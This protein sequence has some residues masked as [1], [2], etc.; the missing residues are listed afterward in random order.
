MRYKT[1]SP[2]SY[3]KSD[4]FSRSF[5]SYDVPSKITHSIIFK[6]T[7]NITGL[8]IQKSWR[9]F[10]IL[11]YVK[12]FSITVIYP[13]NRCSNKQSKQFLICP[14]SYGPFYSSEK[15]FVCLETFYLVL[16]FSVFVHAYLI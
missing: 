6:K 8:K 4:I 3:Y 10:Y 13:V 5:I 16:L 11:L 15:S 1:L 12:C 14:R 2:S 7:R 9:Y